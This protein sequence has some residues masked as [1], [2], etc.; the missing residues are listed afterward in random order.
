MA[1][2]I[3]VFMLTMSSKSNSY[4][5][6]AADIQPRE[7]VSMRIEGTLEQINYEQKTAFLCDNSICIPVFLPDSKIVQ[8][9]K[10][11]IAEGKFHGKDFH[12]SKILTRC[13][14]KSQ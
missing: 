13:D 14:H 8:T 7:N 3:I 1:S 9:E 2:L 5:I 4:A 6:S 12:I 10:R 11:I